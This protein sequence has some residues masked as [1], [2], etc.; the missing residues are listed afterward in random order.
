MWTTSIA[1][2]CKHFP[3]FQDQVKKSLVWLQIPPEALQMHQ[4]VL[5]DTNSS[6]QPSNSSQSKPEANVRVKFVLYDN[7]K[8]F[9]GSRSPEMPVVAASVGRTVVTNLS[10]PVTYFIEGPESVYSGSVQPTCVFWDEICNYWL[11]K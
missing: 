3:H 1:L 5:L 2:K 6:S 8:F 7:G 10:E 4:T 9:R 11:W